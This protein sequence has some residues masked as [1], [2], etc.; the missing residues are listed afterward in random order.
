MTNIFTLRNVTIGGILLM[1]ALAMGIYISS[2]NSPA[3][4]DTHLQYAADFSDDR[5]LV[6]GSHNVF[7]GKVV[8]QVGS[9]EYSST[10]STQFDVEVVKNIKGNLNGTVVVDQLGGYKDGVLYLVH[11]D[12]VTSDDI[13]GGTPLLTQG[14]TYLFTARYNEGKDQYTLITH[15]NGMKLISA[16]AGLE[17]ARLEELVSRDEKVIALEEAYRHEILLDADIRHN[18]TRNSYQ[19]LQEKNR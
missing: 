7:A 16:D 10:P 3:T 11:D 12:T 14:S 19:S 2:V 17:K 15:P 8:K 9:E 6:G 4:S 13:E 5:I 1:S 18:N